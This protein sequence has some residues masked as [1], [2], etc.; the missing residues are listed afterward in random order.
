LALLPKGDLLQHKL[1]LSN[2]IKKANKREQAMKIRYVGVAVTAALFSLASQSSVA[3]EK[4]SDGKRLFDE[5]RCSDC[6][7]KDGI[8]GSSADAP[9]LAGRDADELLVKSKRYIDG[10]PQNLAWKGCGETPNYKEARAISQYLSSLPR[11]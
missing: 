10:N 2:K 6:H 1:A 4:A 5:Y 11:K 9:T 7:G 8:K 3:G